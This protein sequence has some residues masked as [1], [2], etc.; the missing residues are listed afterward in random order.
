ARVAGLGESEVL[1]ALGEQ[2]RDAVQQLAAVRPGGVAPRAGV[3]RAAGRGDRPFG[4][5]GGRLGDLGDGRPGGGAADLAGAAG[6]RRRPRAVD[7]QGGWGG[8][9]AHGAQA[10]ICSVSCV[11]VLLACRNSRCRSYWSST[12][13]MS[14]SLAYPVTS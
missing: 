2:V 8:R 5:G 6:G 10:S 13:A 7:V 12:S 11:G 14:C 9:C 4:V 3:E 1:L